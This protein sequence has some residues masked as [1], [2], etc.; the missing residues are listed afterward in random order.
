MTANKR[1]IDDTEDEFRAALAT[2]TKAGNKTAA[3]RRLWNAAYEKGKMAVV[4]AEAR[5]LVPTPEESRDLDIGATKLRGFAEGRRAGFEEGRR[6]GEKGAMTADGMEIGREKENL[7][8]KELGHLRMHVATA[9]YKTLWLSRE[10][11]P[12]TELLL[13]TTS[14]VCTLNEQRVFRQQQFLVGSFDSH[15][16][17][18][19]GFRRAVGNEDIALLRGVDAVGAF[20]RFRAIGGMLS[21]LFAHVILARQASPGLWVHCSIAYKLIVLASSVSGMKIR[22]KVTPYCK[23]ASLCKSKRV[24]HSGVAKIMLRTLSSC[25]LHSRF[26]ASYWSHWLTGNYMRD[27]LETR[28]SLEYA[29]TSEHL[30]T[31]YYQVGLRQLP[32]CSTLAQKEGEWRGDVKVKSIS[33]VAS[34]S[35]T[36]WALARGGPLNCTFLTDGNSDA[37]IEVLELETVTD[38]VEVEALE[39]VGAVGVERIGVLDV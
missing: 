26:L 12:E 3:M 37:E 16:G 21:H 14:T 11:D 28:Q 27:H 10:Y 19:I 7:R 8:W 25:G 5:H 15:R 6:V 22:P 23:L 38:G 17:C 1:A 36:A 13:F 4:A 33:L 29:P 20:G 2:Y 9:P 34:L 18:L 39:D 24:R 32:Y 35:V 30:T 31:V